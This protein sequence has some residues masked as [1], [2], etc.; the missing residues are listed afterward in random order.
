MVVQRISESSNSAA[1]GN[2]IK[3]VVKINRPSGILINMEKSTG[4]PTGCRIQR[5]SQSYLNFTKQ[6]EHRVSLVESSI[7]GGE[8]NLVRKDRQRQMYG[9]PHQTKKEKIEEIMTVEKARSREVSE[10]GEVGSILRRRHPMGCW[11]YVLYPVITGKLIKNVFMK[12]FKMHKYSE[13]NITN[14]SVSIC[15]SF[16]IVYQIFLYIR[17]K[18]LLRKKRDISSP[19]LLRGKHYQN[20]VSI[21][22]VYFFL[23]SL[24]TFIHSTN[25][26]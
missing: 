5:L 21:L 7:T 6:D 19:V 10:A 16:V 8:R 13:T 20:F 11:E 14:T 12:I 23:L 18:V 15:K 22:Q 17:P 9:V 26:S 3:V 25:T 1:A 4:L 2:Q 24:H